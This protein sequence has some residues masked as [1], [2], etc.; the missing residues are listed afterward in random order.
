[1]SSSSSLLRR[2][3]GAR[4]ERARTGRTGL[5]DGLSITRAVLWAIVAVIVVAPLAGIVLIWALRGDNAL[6]G[7]QAVREAALNSVVSSVVSSIVAV[8]VALV[9]ALLIERTDIAGR[10]TLRLFVLSP[11]LVPPFI[12]AISW[13]G[14]LGPMSPIN[15]WWMKQFGSPLVSVYGAGGVTALL[16]LHSMPIAYVIIQ[17]ALRRIPGDLEEAARVGGA[18]PLRAFADVTAP[19]LVPAVRSALILS[20]VASLAD[21][22]IPSILGSPARYQTL[23]TLIYSYLQSGTVGDP[24]GAVCTIGVLLLLVAIATLVLDAWLAGRAPQ[25]EGGGA[26]A[27]Q[28]LGA[29][30]WLLG[31]VVWLLVLAVTLGPVLALAAESVTPAPGVP[32]TPQT[33]TLAHYTSALGS[34]VVQ[35]GLRTSLMLAALAAVVCTLLGLVVATVTTRTRARSNGVLRGLFVLPQSLP[36]LNI[37]VAWLVIAPFLHIFNTPWVILAAYVT[38]FVGIVVQSVIGPMRQVP[39]VME[40]AARVSGATRARALLDISLRLALASAVSGGVLVFLTALRELTLSA[41]LKSPGSQTLGVVIY[42]LQQSGAF[43]PS[44]ALAF[45]VTAVGL[46]G[47]A[48]AAGRTRQA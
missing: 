41:L 43:G 10:R 23:A 48:V 38:A 21:F 25:V 34:P 16:A 3:A 15:V 42:D 5:P 13:I 29:W 36:G 18:S 12:G 39:T 17:S 11:M 30:R 7:T 32:L 33:F 26:P 46:A 27:V 24:L 4:P 14:L 20:I 2:W 28:R 1:M 47:L 22:G 45:L 9:L 37:A 8:A 6:L 31:A 19:L 44:A 35:T 40:E